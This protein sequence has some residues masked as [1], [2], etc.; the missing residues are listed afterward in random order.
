MQYFER[1]RL[2]WTRAGGVQ[3]ALIGDEALQRRGWLDAGGQPTNAAT[4]ARPS[5]E[6]EG[7]RYFPETGHTLAGAF[8]EAWTAAGGVTDLGFPR[9]AVLIAELP[10]G[11]QLL[12]QY[13][14]RGRLEQ[15]I[16]AMPEDWFWF[17][18]RWRDRRAERAARAQ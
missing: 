14:Q 16:R 2:E 6:G 18:R 17:H 13:T 10:D 4:L 9:T 8:L 12:T 11:G 15:Q 5:V 7:V 1:G 3:I